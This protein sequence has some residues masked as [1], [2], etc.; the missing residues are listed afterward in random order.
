MT[1]VLQMGQTIAYPSH[2]QWLGGHL[3]FHEKLTYGGNPVGDILGDKLVC[4]KEDVLLLILESV[5]ERATV[6]GCM[7]QLDSADEEHIVIITIY[8]TTN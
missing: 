3:D 8:N 6:R 7:P 2:L 4:G 5:S 1:Y